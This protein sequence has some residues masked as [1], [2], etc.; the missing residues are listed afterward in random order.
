M[1]FLFESQIQLIILAAGV[2]GTIVHVLIEIRALYSS[3]IA[4][5]NLDI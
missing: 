1:L 3:F 5:T 2:R 4:H